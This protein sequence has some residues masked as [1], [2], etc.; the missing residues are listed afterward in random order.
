MRKWD[1]LDFGGEEASAESV[2]YSDSGRGVAYSSGTEPSERRLSSS[3]GT[4]RGKTRPREVV[5]G[6]LF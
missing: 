1:P 5:E 4:I 2:L 3:T 6:E